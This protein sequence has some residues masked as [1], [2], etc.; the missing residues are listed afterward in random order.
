MFA[1]F[2]TNLPLLEIVTSKLTSRWIYGKDITNNKRRYEMAETEKEKNHSVSKG[3][4]VLEQLIVPMRYLC[5]GSICF[6][7]W[8]GSLCC[9]NLTYVFIVLV[10]FR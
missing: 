5:C 2:V 4:R 10:K 7:F 8:S 1:T 9:L 3:Q 6:I